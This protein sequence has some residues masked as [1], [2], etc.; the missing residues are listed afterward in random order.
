M[1][2]LGSIL[3]QQQAA[4]PNQEIVLQ[5]ANG[6]VSLNDAQQTAAIVEQELQRIGAVSIHVG[7]Q[8]D[9]RLV[10][11][12]YSGTDVENIKK[13]L[14]AQKDLALGFIS[15]TKNENP[16]RVPSK[17]TSIAYQLDVYEIK[18]GQTTYSS[19]GGQC[20]VELKSAKQRLLN[21]NLYI[22]SHQ[23][24]FAC[25]EPI[26]KVDFSFQRSIAIVEDF[27]SHK[28][29]EVRAGPLS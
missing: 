22:A 3:G 2:V 29:P 26:L 9:G 28:I 18:D 7:E 21:P 12:Y 23:P 19:L 11:S 24:F 16:L 13:L 8:E 17:D 20:A 5:F 6:D 1:A 27:R 25:G 4:V 15:S 14:S 10:I